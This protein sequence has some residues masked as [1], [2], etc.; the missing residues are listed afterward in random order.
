[1]LNGYIGEHV[2]V[3][4]SMFILHETPTEFCTP[5]YLFLV[6]HST[7]VLQNY[8]TSRQTFIH[9]GHGRIYVV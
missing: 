2:V 6:I 9:L 4:D 5:P 7:V 1:M 8:F 3:L